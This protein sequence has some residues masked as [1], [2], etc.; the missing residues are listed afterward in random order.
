MRR[1]SK[2]DSVVHLGI[3]LFINSDTGSQDACMSDVSCA[4]GGLRGAG[5]VHM[6]RRD[7]PRPA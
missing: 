6:R 4:A 3:L 7:M 1:R 2:S 5:G